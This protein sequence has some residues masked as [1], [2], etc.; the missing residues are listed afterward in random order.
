V[1]VAA[2]LAAPD[3]LEGVQGEVAGCRLLLE[4]V[5]VAGVALVSCCYLLPLLLLLEGALA[6]VAVCLRQG[7][8]VHGEGV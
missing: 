2:S 3:T 1:G 5:L 4:G 6:G 7:Q 8:H